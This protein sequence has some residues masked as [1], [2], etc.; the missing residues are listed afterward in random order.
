[1][2]RDSW[3]GPPWPAPSPKNTTATRPAPFSRAAKAAPRASGT[4]PPTTPLAVTKPDSAATTCMDPP[5]PRQ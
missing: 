3:N 4:V 1:M 2:F 5:L